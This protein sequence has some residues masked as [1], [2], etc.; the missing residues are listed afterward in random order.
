MYVAPRRVPDVVAVRS[1]VAAKAEE[2]TVRITAAI[3]TSKNRFM[4]RLFLV[5]LKTCLFSRDL[6]L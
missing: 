4:L 3:P 2:L 1:T 5:D 6:N